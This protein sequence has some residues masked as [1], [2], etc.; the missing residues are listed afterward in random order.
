MTRSP[1]S[2]ADAA[3]VK[4]EPLNG[5]LVACTCPMIDSTAERPSNEIVCDE[6]A[7]GANCGGPIVAV[8]LIDGGTYVS[9][10]VWLVWTELPAVADE[11]TV[12]PASIV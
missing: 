5:G 4:F 11:L 10:S 12:P 9:L 3:S 8:V 2:L 6:S 1:W 7:W